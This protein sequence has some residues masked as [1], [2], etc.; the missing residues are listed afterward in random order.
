MSLR[1]QDLVTRQAEARPERIAIVCNRETVT[2]GALETV[3]NRL[4]HLLREVGCQKGDRVCLFLP[5]GSS[6]IVGMLAAVKAG[7]AYVPIDIASPA[8]RVARILDAC[9]PAVALVL[10]PATKLVDE[11]TASRSKV[12]PAI[13]A[14]EGDAVVGQHFRSAFDLRDVERAPAALPAETTED[15]V[16]HIL[17]TSG[18]TG[19]PK[20]VMITHKNVTTFLNWACPYFGIAPDDRTSGHSPFH[21]DLS[22]FDIYGTLSSGAALHLVTPEMNLIAAKLAAMIRDSQL[23]QWFS[24]PS[25]LTYLMQFDAVRPNDFP[26]LKRLLWCGE[27][28]PTPTLIYL[29]ERL[30]HVTFTNLYGPTE[31]TIASSYYTV[32]A[33]P[34]DDR[35]AIPIGEACGGEYLLVLD[36]KRQPVAPGEIGDLF[37][38]GD[39]LSPGYWKDAEKTAAAFLAHPHEADQRIYRT[40][41]LARVDEAGLFYF[42][43]RCDSQIKSR[44]YRI[45]LGEIEAALNP[46]PA[47]GECAVVGVDSKGFEGT[48]IC[49]AYAAAPGFAATPTGIRR[50]LAAALP[51]YMMPSRWKSYDRL[52]KNANGKIDKRAIREA[53]EQELATAPAVEP[54]LTANA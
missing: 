54:P 18:S 50:E 25:I 48:L 26:A 44:G 20:G 45:E 14:L 33:R 37:I 52:P 4:A 8:N 34:T 16:A 51:S 10:R 35:A 24:V 53:F 49:C 1:L 32:P 11:L 13:I 15:D 40:G 39:G 7:A 31:A 2:Y 38:G 28:M 41:D 47:I 19:V 3:T 21:F 30:P 43:G 27:A 22:T 17:F 5:K 36:D 42:L 29:M 6:A 23:T 12:A 46:L 9:E